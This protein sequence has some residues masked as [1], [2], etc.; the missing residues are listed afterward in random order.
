MPVYH[1][2][3]AMRSK[4]ETVV[5]ADDDINDTIFLREALKETY[6]GIKV[7]SVSVA[8]ELTKTL[9]DI[10]TPNAIFLDLY[11]AGKN[12]KQ[13]LKEIRGKAKFDGVQI[14]MLSDSEATDDFVY[15]LA[16]GANN[17]LAKPDRYPVLVDAVRS[18]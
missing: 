7:I 4:F 6:P 9:D 16:N 14:I 10:E 15:C 17:I 11:L 8:S 1:N 12:G 2:T 13:C 3:P 5:I 18:L